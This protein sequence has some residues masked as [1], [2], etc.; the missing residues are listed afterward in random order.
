MQPAGRARP[1]LSSTALMLTALV[2]ASGLA[3]GSTA[4]AEPPLP[5]SEAGA[6]PYAAEAAV[7][8]HFARALQVRGADAA[9]RS[10]SGRSLARVEAVLERNG[11]VAVQPLMQGTAAAR[12]PGLQAKAAAR[13]GE[14]PPDLA[15]WYRV[16]LRPGTDDDGTQAV[17]SLLSDLRALPEVV[18]AEP[19]PE[20][21]P[22]PGPAAPTTP[23]F[24]AL[25]GYLR[26]AP[27]G[28]D[29]DFAR[30]DPRTRGAGIT[31]IDLEYD[32]NPFH[33]DLQLDWSSDVGGAEFPRYT[34]FGDDH[35][36]AVFGQL[37]GRK[38]GYG[39]LGGA[40]E[41]EMLGISPMHQIGDRRLYNPGAALIA[42]GA[43]MEPGDVMLIEQQIAGPNGSQQYVPLEWNTAAFQAMVLLD[44]LG[45]VVVE[46]G[47][48]GGQD[49]DG[50]EFLGRFDRTV[51]D[52]NAIV[53]GAGDSG[54]HRA[55]GYSSFG[56][57]LDL[58]GWGND[59]TTTGYGDLFDG[60]DETGARD[61]TGMF[62]GTSGAS[63]IVTSAVVAV[64]SYLKA[65][66]QEPWSADQITALLRET[67]TPQPG[68]DRPDRPVDPRPETS[69]ALTGTGTPQ[70]AP[71]RPIGPLPDLAAALRE[72]EV[73][74][75]VSTATVVRTPVRGRLPEQTVTLTAHDGW[76]SGVART[77][78]RIG[79]AS[80]WTTYTRPFS[81]G[82]EG[83]VQFRSVDRR[84]NVEAPRTLPVR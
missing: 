77:E 31:I 15:S 55:L 66:G 1:L 12:L 9:L 63:P 57:R 67:G 18:H 58:Q 28:V 61:Y 22:P 79:A 83:R 19:A 71:T 56:S 76:G 65:T 7:E 84:G 33:E 60:G 49:L 53:V 13:S 30:A 70:P 50:P 8:V 51:R 14:S 81:V 59:I 23:D 69:G 82:A 46:A 11:A 80:L 16:V 36:T 17:R 64:Q 2:A 32:W 42:A 4:H 38:N 6:A 78:Y 62:G 5:T 47:G 41:A 75:P 20:A 73:D 35:G 27:A 37:V 25:Q 10:G 43:L 40:P 45:V 26:P 3:A 54:S 48:N 34:A 21:A 24:F 74:A 68:P 29:A 39:V 44:Q 72:I 52:S